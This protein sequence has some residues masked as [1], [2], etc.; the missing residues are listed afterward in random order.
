MQLERLLSAHPLPR[1]TG[2]RG[3]FTHESPDVCVNG[4]RNMVCLA[5]IRGAQENQLASRWI[6]RDFDRIIQKSWAPIR[7]FYGH[8]AQAV[9]AAKD[10]SNLTNFYP[11][12]AS[13]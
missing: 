7:H 5:A 6:G 1:S 11:L 2:S 3:S 9:I 4:I 8:P 12:R 10:G 13:V